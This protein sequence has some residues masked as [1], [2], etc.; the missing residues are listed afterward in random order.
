MG[1]AGIICPRDGTKATLAR[2]GGKLFGFDI[3]ACPECGGVWL[4]KGEFAKM[5]DSRD[6][7][8]I[9]RDYAGGKSEVTCPRDQKPMGRRPLG[10]IVV[11][12]CPECSG[13]WFDGGEMETAAAS[14]KALALGVGEDDLKA[15]TDAQKIRYSGLKYIQSSVGISA[16][17]G[18]V[19]RGR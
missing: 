2:E 15:Y 19:A 16:A 14:A 4:D 18:A 11:D 12:V 6:A 13:I 8:K 17:A 9:I 10:D 3:D 1:E 5:V 7:E